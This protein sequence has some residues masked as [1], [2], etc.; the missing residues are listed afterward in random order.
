MPS[1]ALV[2]AVGRG[3]QPFPVLRVTWEARGYSLGSG[4]YAPAG[5]LTAAGQVSA[6]TKAGGWEP[7]EYGSGIKDSQLD[8]VETAVSV[9]DKDG[10]LLEMLETYDPRGSAA[11]IDRA[12][13]A[14]VAADWEP[15]FRGVVADWARDGLFTVLKLK[16]DDTVLRTPVPAGT[17]ER[18]L[19]G[20]AAEPTIY[21][22]H[23]PLLTGIHD[24]WQISARGMVAAPNVRYD[25]TQGYWWLA[26]IDQMIE[27]TRVY[28][29]G[30][31]MGNV[32]WSVVRQVIGQHYCTFIVV[33]EGYQPSK[34][35]ILSFDCKGPDED[36]L[37][38]GS[39][40]TGAPDQLRMIIN[41]YG[42]RT[43]PLRGWRGDTSVIDATSWD[44]ASEFFALHTVEA[45]R[46]FGGEQNPESVAEVIQSFLD[47]YPFVRICWTPLGT[48]KFGIIDPDDVDPTDA[49]RF[50]LAKFHEGGQVPFAP[51][52]QREVY[53]HVKTAF[54]WSAAEQ[55]YVSEYQAH[56]V[57]ALPEK[58]VLPLENPWSQ[59]RLT[60]ATPVN[61]APPADPVP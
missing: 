53:T 12:A 55:K 48:L 39:T 4:I 28:F 5:R 30:I 16:T 14:L 54:M 61:P 18:T 42:Y 25:V 24:S 56:D 11:S 19:W 26:S 41:E 36:G 40:L 9:A 6:V 35:V 13:P 21:G 33:A 50:D 49:A 59:C 7:I 47:A 58:V 57:A 17:F 31:P 10:T 20:S 3:A 51:G 32:G 15:R 37:I 52:D 22:T 23:L 38:V 8:A 29:D 43:P 27:I 2:E 1:A 34:G 45:A 44:A 60:Q 46:S